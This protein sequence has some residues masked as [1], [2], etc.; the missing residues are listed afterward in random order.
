MVAASTTPFFLT[1]Y[2]ESRKLFSTAPHTKA[3]KVSKNSHAMKCLVLMRKLIGRVRNSRD[4]DPA[5]PEYLRDWDLA[6]PTAG[7]RVFLGFL[8]QFKKRIYLI[9][10][11]C[12]CGINSKGKYI[13]SEGHP[14]RFSEPRF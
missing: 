11:V 2:F 3:K 1:P 4:R 14:V 12:C 5:N 10:I 9:Q 7:S 8:K 13:Q 6:I